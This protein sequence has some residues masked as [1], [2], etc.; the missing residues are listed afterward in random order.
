MTKEKTQEDKPT[1]SDY[2]TSKE[3]LKKVMTDVGKEHPD[4]SSFTL[5]KLTL[6]S[7]LPQQAL[8]SQYAIQERKSLLGICYGAEILTLTLGGTIKKS[9]TP[10]QGHQKIT[11]SGKNP[12]SV[13]NS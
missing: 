9:S 5:R 4:S 3:E 13:T 2:K 10:Q 8:L 1:I 12:C 7:V 6:F 11:I